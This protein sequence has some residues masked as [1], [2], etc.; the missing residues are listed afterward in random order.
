MQGA[1][2]ATETT[3]TDKPISMRRALGQVF[4]A[5]QRLR[6][7]ECSRFEN[8]GDRAVFTIVMNRAECATP[9]RLGKLAKAAEGNGF[10]VVASK[11]HEATLRIECVRSVRTVGI[12]DRIGRDGA[13]T[14][15]TL[16]QAAPVRL[17]IV[18]D[19]GIEDRNPILL[20]RT[21]D[22]VEMWVDFVAGEP[23]RMVHD[24]R[25]HS[26]PALA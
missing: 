12:V 5:M 26:M 21:G 19:A 17:W 16:V 20:T 15:L 9:T 25:N 23:G 11:I 6:L 14:I 7:G 2:G 1:Q 18:V 24:F 10:R 3:M 8:G 13:S 4:E 22:Q